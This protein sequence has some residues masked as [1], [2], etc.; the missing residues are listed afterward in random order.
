MFRQEKAAL[1]LL[2]AVFLIALFYSLAAADQAATP[3]A[4][5]PNGGKH[6]APEHFSS[7][8]S[9][10][11]FM[12]AAPQLICGDLNNDSDINLG[13]AVFMINFIFAGGPEPSLEASDVNCDITKNIGDAVYLINFVFAGGPGPCDA[14]PIYP[15]TIFITDNDGVDWDITHAVFEYGMEARN[16][17]FGLGGFAFSPINNPQIVKP[18]EP[19]FPDA[20]ESFEVIGTV[21][22][23]QARAYAVSDVAGH[24]VVN[25]TIGGVHLAATY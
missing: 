5:N 14:C 1:L 18:G 8:S 9:T 21:I 10:D 17:R 22:N 12:A 24:E 19:G 11:H 2:P 7:Q 4:C 13:D 20:S 15:D 16:W 6:I 23:G 3:T 25:D